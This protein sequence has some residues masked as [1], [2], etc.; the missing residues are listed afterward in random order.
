MAQSE[1]TRQQADI[2]V[3]GSGVAGALVA[4]ELARA[5]KSVLMLE[6]G[7]RLPRWEI[8]E[9]FRNHD[10]AVGLPDHDQHRRQH[11]R[12]AHRRHA[13]RRPPSTPTT[14]YAIPYKHG[15]LAFFSVQSGA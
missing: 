15:T 5:G 2:V 13:A 7:P 1:Q 12:T 11:V 9:R 8:V 14:S 6:A 4:Y 3:V 10:A